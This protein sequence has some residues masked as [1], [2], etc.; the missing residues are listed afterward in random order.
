MQKIKIKILYKDPTTCPKT[1]SSHP[2]P[3]PHISHIPP[4][5]VWRREELLQAVGTQPP[6]HQRE[7]SKQRSPAQR[8]EGWKTEILSVQCSEQLA[9]TQSYC[10]E[11]SETTAAQAPTLILFLGTKNASNCT[12]TTHNNCT[13]L[14]PTSGR[15]KTNSR[16]Y[17]DEDRGFQ[18]WPMLTWTETHQRYHIVFLTSTFGDIHISVANDTEATRN[19]TVR[20]I[21][22]YS[23]PLK[24]NINQ[25]ESQ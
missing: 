2:S 4:L 13:N 21:S 22:F 15:Q 1:S 20:Q 5:S 17:Q 18:L 14:Q 11:H 3:F 25:H 16:G 19:P 10:K 8:R 9:W 6:P 24:A 7:E 12:T 23:T